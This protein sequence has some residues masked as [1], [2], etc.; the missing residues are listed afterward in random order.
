MP[1]PQDNQTLLLPETSLSNLFPLDQLIK[2]D[3]TNDNLPYDKAIK[4]KIYLII[5]E[6]MYDQ[7]I[8]DLSQ[9][10][11]G[12]YKELQNRVEWVW[13]TN[14]GTLPKRI[15]S[16][17]YELAKENKLKKV[18]KL[19]DKI[20]SAIGTLVAKEKPTGKIHYFDFTTKFNW[21]AGQ[22]GD[23]GSCF[24]SSN[25]KTN[26]IKWLE[27]SGNVFSIRFFN[28]LTLAA[29]TPMMDNLPE[30]WYKEGGTSYRGIARAWL[31]LSYDQKINT[32]I[33]TAFNAYGHD[34][35]YIVNVLESYLHWTALA[36]NASMRWST[37]HDEK[38]IAI[39]NNTSL[40][41]NKGIVSCLTNKKGIIRNK[42]TKFSLDAIKN[43]TD[44]KEVYTPK[45]KF[46]YPFPQGTVTQAATMAC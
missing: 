21:V 24:L 36:S 44:G 20:I 5:R 45:L 37:G 15:A 12:M 18:R 30:A 13:K 33:L 34:L 14:R 19:S 7:D 23:A 43:P 26:Y 17:F 27:E 11:R 10:D 1:T 29:D 31:M 40:Y 9:F 32:S 42:I 28:P 22:F 6:W 35:K 4:D 38:A 25:E 46:E 8:F 39:D 2:H 16:A 3:T 41:V